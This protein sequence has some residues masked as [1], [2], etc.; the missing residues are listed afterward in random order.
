ML[1]QSLATQVS[2]QGLTDEFAE[3]DLLLV[4]CILLSLVNEMSEGEEGM[5]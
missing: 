2:Q 3:E 1:D 4:I 5:D